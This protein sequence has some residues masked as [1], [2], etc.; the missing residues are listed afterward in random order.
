VTDSEGSA[1]EF[2]CAFPVKVIG[3]SG[4]DLDALVFRLVRPHAPDLGEGAIRSRFSSQGR[5]QSVTVTV[6]ATSRAQ[7]DAIYRSLTA[8]DDILMVL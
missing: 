6:Q 1:F 7:L 3:K 5:Y 2:P 8:C 4:V